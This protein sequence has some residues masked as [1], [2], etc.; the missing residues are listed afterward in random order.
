MTLTVV[1]KERHPSIATIDRKHNL[2]LPNGIL[3]EFPDIRGLPGF[4]LTCAKDL[5]SLRYMC[6]GQAENKG[7]AHVLCIGN[8]LVLSR[9]V[10]MEPFDS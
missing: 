5:A 2:G 3:P 10:A 8:D 9:S 6:P 7:F 1:G 4:K